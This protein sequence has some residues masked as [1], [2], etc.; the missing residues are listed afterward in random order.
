MIET[1][2]AGQLAPAELRMVEPE[3]ER[4]Q[5]ALDTAQEQVAVFEAKWKSDPGR[6]LWVQLYAEWWA[7]VE[8]A[9][10][11]IARLERRS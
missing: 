1:E 6:W 11:A 8:I 7:E 3:R 4:L 2:D 10:R 9:R 5:F